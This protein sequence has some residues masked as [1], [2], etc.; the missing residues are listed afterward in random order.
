V[1]VQF[2]LNG[3]EEEKL[4]PLSASD[5]G[6]GSGRVVV[7]YGLDVAV[8]DSVEVKVDGDTILKGA[9][10]GISKRR[11]EGT[12]TLSCL[13]KT[14]VL[15]QNFILNTSHSSYESEDAGAIAK[16]LIDTYFAGVLTSTNVNTA[17][18]VTVSSVDFYGESVGDALEEL[19]SRAGCDFY[20]DYSDDCHF[21]LSGT[22]SSGLTIN[23]SD[24]FDVPYQTETGE[25]VSKVVVDG[26]GDVSGSAGSGYPM[27]YFKDRKISTNT[28][29]GEV[30]AALLAKYNSALENAS[31]VTIGFWKLRA[32]QSVVVDSPKDGFSASAETVQRVDWSF[33]AGSVKTTVTVGDEDF[34]GNP[35]EW[36][37]R[38]VAAKLENK[39]D[40]WKL[41]NMFTWVDIQN[42]D[43]AHEMANLI[44]IPDEVWAVKLAK[45]HVYAEKFRTHSR[46]LG[47]QAHKHAISGAPIDEVPTVDARLPLTDI[48]GN[49][50][51]SIPLDKEGANAPVTGTGTSHVHDIDYGIYEEDIAGRTLSAELFDPN[52]ISLHDFGVITTGEDDAELDLTQYFDPIVTGGAH[53]TYKLVLTAS[54]RIRARTINYLRCALN[55]S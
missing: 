11:R 37:I 12:K 34:T 22:E 38:Q 23:A 30:A 47:E 16:D 46:T 13:G 44:W 10:S 8:G 39:H 27:K 31:I 7:P 5:E 29:A 52:D 4:L 9:V 21:F 26:Q 28:E 1:R 54:G 51:G 42:L 14:N 40:D 43:D 55:A 15:F 3:A 17:T 2:L 19:C 20:V 36:A 33:T 18:G 25:V 48:N 6:R 32:K 49:D 53:P 24:I 50:V 35:L 45:V 41:I